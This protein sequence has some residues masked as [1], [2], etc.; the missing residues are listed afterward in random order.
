MRRTIRNVAA[1]TLVELLVVIAIIGILIALLLPAVQ[2]ARE[3]A[4]RMQCSN[5]FKQLVLAM[6]NYHQSLGAFPP[7]ALAC[8]NLSWN[9]FILPYIEQ[10]SLYDVFEHHG[11]F[12]QGTFNE[13]TNNEGQNKGNLIAMSSV[14]AFHCPSNPVLEAWH[15]SSLPNNPDRVTY[16][17]HYYGVAG[18]GRQ[19]IN[20]RTGQNYSGLA[21]GSYGGFSWDGVMLVD[22]STK[23]RDITDGTSN[24]FMLSEMAPHAD[25]I[26]RDGSNWVR[27]TGWN[28]GAPG[29]SGGVT[30][31]AS[32]KNVAYGINMPI[33]TPFNDQAFGSEHPGGA[34]FARADGSASFVSETIDMAVYASTCSRNGGEVQTVSSE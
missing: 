22:R 9:C 24:T 23:I 33:V 31:S 4:R 3:A 11:T 10:Q 1:F 19:L 26:G 21:T 20:P 34:M 13:G 7:G 32:T 15:G 12:N 28:T 8:N 25:G 17:S 16:A 27:G 30:S 14:S 29:A 5:N 18:P 6:H 2:A